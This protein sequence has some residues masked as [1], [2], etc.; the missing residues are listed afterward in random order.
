MLPDDKTLLFTNSGMVQFKKKFLDLAEKETEYGKLARACNYQK[1][2]RAGGKHNDLDDVGKD[3]YHHTFFEMLGNWSFGDYFKETAIDLAWRFLTDVLQLEKERLY[4]SYFK[5]DASQGLSEDSEAK[6]L[7]KKHIPDERRI[8][9]FG[10]KENFWEMGNTGP[11]GPCSEIHYD[12]IGGRDAAA[13]VNQ[14]DPDVVEIWNIVFI[15]YNR[16]ETPPLTLL[17]KK[18]VDTGM[19]LERVL[20]ILQKQRSN[21]NTELFQPLFATIAARMEIAP[22]GDTLESKV[23]TAYR[24]IADHSRT[25]AISLMDGILPSNEGRGYVI[26][27]ILRRALGFQYQHMKKQPGLLPALVEQSFAEMSQCYPTSTRVEKVVQ[28]IQEEETQFTKTLSKGLAILT[29]KIEEVKARGSDNTLSGE[30]AFILYDRYGFPI[31][32]TQAVA[33]QEGVSVAM[34]GFQREQARAKELSKGSGKAAET[35]SLTVHDLFLLEQATGNT[36]TDDSFKYRRDPVQSRVVGIKLP[37]EPVALSDFARYQDVPSCGVILARTSFYGEAG[38]Q[39]GDRGR[40]LLTAQAADSAVEER[41]ATLALAPSQLAVQDTK[42]YGKYVVH[43]G[44]LEGTLLPYATCEIDLK[45]RKKLAISHTSTHLL[46]FAVLTS[47]P[48]ETEEPKQCGSLVSEDRLRFDFLWSQ[49]LTPEQVAAIEASVNQLVAAQLPVHVQHLKYQEAMQIPGLRHMKDE[50]YPEVVR[51]VMVGERP[52][53]IEAG[54]GHSVELCGGTHVSNSGEIERV[55]IISEA[56][57]ARGIRRITALCGAAALQ[58]E[59]LAQELL[60]HPLGTSVDFNA[61]KDLVE[62][63]AVPLRELGQLRQKLDG[64]QKQLTQRRKA[65]FEQELRTFREQ[66]STEDKLLFVC[67]QCPDLPASLASKMLAPFTQALEK[68][69]KEG[70]VLYP[71]EDSVLFWAVLPNG[72]AALKQALAPADPQVAVRG[73]DAKANG[74]ARTSL[75]AAASLLAPLLHQ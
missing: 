33:E 23:D 35:L 72:A 37:N 14:D 27:R 1:C 34:D 58:A 17:P 51:V 9:G 10:A 13:L 40:L 50:E 62:K 26:R 45:R 22:Y 71:L 60:A 21:Y 48:V 15:Q 8:L 42:K 52:L 38:G 57:V 61:L 55:R 28:V 63:S 56:S 54:P 41:M 12:R 53:E 74:S 25:L 65:H 68:S 30:D 43:L 67:A 64:F 7:W 20:S 11:C 46:N 36:P 59:A 24:V 16:E 75:A 2:I 3:T 29:G 70:V 4:V 18:H 44:Q 69:Q 31:D 49:P 47:L 32:L 73:K 39:E 5:G 66:L 19:G 6:R